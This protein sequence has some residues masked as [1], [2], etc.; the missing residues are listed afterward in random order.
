M[1]L[2]H[3]TF[4]RQGRETSTARKGGDAPMRVDQSDG[5]AVVHCT[6]EAVLRTADR[7]ADRSRTQESVVAP[8][9]ESGAPGRGECGAT[10]NRLLGIPAPA[11]R[12]PFG[13]PEDARRWLR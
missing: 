4:D 10:G 8:R 12:V 11:L 6:S 9:G 13:L 2:S 7:T 3:P 5:D 1:G